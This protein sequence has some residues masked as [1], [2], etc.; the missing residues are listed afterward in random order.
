MNDDKYYDDAYAIYNLIEKYVKYKV[1]TSFLAEVIHVVKN[2]VNIKAIISE[3]ENEDNPIINN[4]LI[5]YPFTSNYSIQI[6][7]EKGDIGLAI[8]CKNDIT[9]YKSKGKPAVANTN[10]KFDIND[11]IFIP[12]SLFNTKENEDKEFTIS[13]KDNSSIIKITNEEILIKSDKIKIESKG[14]SLSDA[15]ESVIQLIDIIGDSLAGSGTNNAAYK[16]AAPAIKQ[17]INSILI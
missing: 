7:I 2:K 12:L 4:V 15:I 16:A 11:S 8:I 14:G 6:P 10:R 13:N 1:N 17:K 5:G 9:T 3:E